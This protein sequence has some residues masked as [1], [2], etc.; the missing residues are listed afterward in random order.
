MTNHPRRSMKV[1]TLH[2]TL[3][4]PRQGSRE[5]SWIDEVTF[6]GRTFHVTRKS[7]TGA[8]DSASDARA[9]VESYLDGTLK[10]QVV[11]EM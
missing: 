4:T 1:R 3:C 7:M 8:F 2:D 9:T 6:D 5:W 10:A 11:K